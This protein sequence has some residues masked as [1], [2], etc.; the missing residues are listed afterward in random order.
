MNVELV[1]DD[2]MLQ[3][4]L[5]ASSFSTVAE[6]SKIRYSSQLDLIKRKCWF[7]QDKLEKIL[8]NLLSNAFKF[9]P[10]GGNVKIVARYIGEKEEIL[11][12]IVEI[13]VSDDGIGIPED[14]TEKIFDRFY[15]VN[16][17]HRKAGSGTGIGLSIVKDMI[18]LLHGEIELHSREDKGSTFIIRFPV[19]KEILKETNFKVKRPLPGTSGHQARNEVEKITPRK[20]YPNLDVK[21]TSNGNPILLIVEDNDD[22]R[23]H[24]KNNLEEDYLVEEANDGISGFSKAT[25]LIPD[26]VI[27]DIMMPNM[28]GTELTIKLKSDERTSHIPIIILTARAT[29]NDK[30][31]G[32]QYGADEYLTKPFSMTELKARI[33]NLIQQR[34]KL[35]ERFSREFLF[36]T[37]GNKIISLDEKFIGRLTGIIMEHIHEENFDLKLLREEMNMSKSTLFRKVHAITDQSPSELICTIRLKYAAELLSKG[38]GNISEVAFESGFKNP[39]YFAKCFRKLYGVSPKEF[40]KS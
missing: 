40:T 24:L 2:I 5:I 15:Q 13:S 1:E 22:V 23:E 27:A 8:S 20:D 9:A 12:E 34:R 14:Q 30:V 29:L 25:E 4:Q 31:N 37:A 16:P 33:S 26:L 18:K 10:E 3:I 6:T 32:L 39:S 38:S 21:E 19:G 7:D 36:G 28:D 17:E 11:P 35:R